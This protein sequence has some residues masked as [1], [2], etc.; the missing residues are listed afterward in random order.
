MPQVV[1][2]PSPAVLRFFV[3]DPTV[4]LSRPR[5]RL[6]VAVLSTMGDLEPLL[7][8]DV[9]TIAPLPRAVSVEVEWDTGNHDR[10]GRRRASVPNRWK[11]APP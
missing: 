8:L 11:T 2:A 3:D 4:V 9:E 6:S 1:V 5:P 7:L 10:P